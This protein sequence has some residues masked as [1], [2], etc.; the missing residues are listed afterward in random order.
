MTV[1]ANVRETYV[2][3]RKDIGQIEGMRET[4]TKKR[5]KNSRDEHRGREGY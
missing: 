3:W 5:R 4:Q 1:L 2:E